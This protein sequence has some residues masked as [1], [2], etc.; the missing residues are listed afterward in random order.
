[1]IVLDSNVISE[2]MRD[3]ADP[4]VVSWIRGQPHTAIAS[5][6]A[7]EITYGIAQLP[8]GKRKQRLVAVWTELTRNFSRNVLHLDLTTASIA[9]IL[10]ADQE[11]RRRPMTVADASIAATCQVHGLP[12]ATRNVKDFKGMGLELVNP[13]DPTLPETD[14]L[15]GGGNPERTPVQGSGP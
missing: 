8:N 1:V 10:I 5:V 11:R 15:Q 12:L 4:Q 14:D 7:L 2:L 13:W 3:Q 6:T 9:G